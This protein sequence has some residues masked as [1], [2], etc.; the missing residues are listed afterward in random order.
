VRS[1]RHVAGKRAAVNRCSGE[2]LPCTDCRGLHLLLDIT[3]I[4][5][6]PDAPEFTWGSIAGLTGRRYR[7]RRR[8]VD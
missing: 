5:G 2:G 4:M 1:G 8:F 3:C 6:V 7:G